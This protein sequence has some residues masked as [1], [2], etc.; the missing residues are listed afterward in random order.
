MSEFHEGRVAA[1]F[2]VGARLE[3]T[4]EVYEKEITGLD[5]MKAALIM[6][7]K[8]LQD[9]RSHLHVDGAQAKVP[10]READIGLKYINE[11]IEILQKMYQDTEAKRFAALGA[12]EA[13]KRVVADTKRLWDEEKEKLKHIKEFEA[14][15]PHDM[16]KRPVG[17]MPA[18]KP[19]DEYKESTAQ[20]D[21]Q[22]VLSESAKSDEAPASKSTPKR[23]KKSSKTSSA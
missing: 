18:E 3:D 21:V 19:I 17:Y 22:P 7:V 15:R 2:Q 5:G 4:K 6:A 23:A 9:H 8:A 10:I 16:T 20:L 1:T 14:E 11:C 13:L 12:I